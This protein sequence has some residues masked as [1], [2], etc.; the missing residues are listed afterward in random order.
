[1]LVC[2]CANTSPIDRVEHMID[3]A[4][5]ASAASTSCRSASA[6]PLG[7]VRPLG[8]VLLYSWPVQPEAAVKVPSRSENAAP[9][10]AAETTTLIPTNLR[11][12][13]ALT[14]AVTCLAYCRVRRLLLVG[15][16]SGAVQV[17]SPSAQWGS[18]QYR[19]ALEAHVTAVER[20]ILRPLP[21]RVRHAQTLGDGVVRSN[22]PIV[23][24]DWA[25]AGRAG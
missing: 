4:G 3:A 5:A 1:M 12:Y 24:L 8:A 6:D 25:R 14:S 2:G 22:H 15:C 17:Y 9:S 20:V 18:V 11:S 21:S 16:V 7:T 23:R 13:I 10:D 19:F